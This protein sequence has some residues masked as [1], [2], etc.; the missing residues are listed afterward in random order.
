MKLNWVQFVS[1]GM[2]RFDKV[3]ARS[4]LSLYEVSV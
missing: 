1:G 2:L 3:Y 4:Q